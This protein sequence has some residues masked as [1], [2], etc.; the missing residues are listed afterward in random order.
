[1]PGRTQL[2]LLST[3]NSVHHSLCHGVPAT[4]RTLLSR[5][6]F[7][8]QSLNTS[9]AGCG[10]PKGSQLEAWSPV[11]ML[12]IEGHQEEETR[13]KYTSHGQGLHK[14]RMSY[15]AGEM[16]Q[17]LRALGCSCRGPGFIFSTHIVLTIIHDSSSGGDLTPYSVLHRHQAHTWY[18]CSQDTCIKQQTQPNLSCYRTMDSVPEGPLG[19]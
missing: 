9:T 17:W 15:G 3:Q 12:S 8:D 19:L 18:A 2:P 1:M 5:K 13:T 16:A 11:V 10:F 14:L 4:I 7:L 6:S